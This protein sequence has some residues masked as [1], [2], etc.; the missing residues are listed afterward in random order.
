MRDQQQKSVRR[1]AAF[2]SG[3]TR[4]EGKS[5]V[6]R[7]VQEKGASGHFRCGSKADK[8][9]MRRDVRFTPESGL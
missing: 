5:N 2:E 9:I 4:F 7:E 3:H 6:H 8:A 1:F